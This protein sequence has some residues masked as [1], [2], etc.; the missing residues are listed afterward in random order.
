MKPTGLVALFAWLSLVHSAWAQGT[1]EVWIAQLASGPPAVR[2]QAAAALARIADPSAVPPL[3]AALR[4]PEVQVRREAAKALGAIKPA[5]AAGPLVQALRDRDANVRTHAAYALGEIKD[6]ATGDAL[7]A[8]LSDPE[9]SVRDQAAWALRQLNDPKLVPA[10]VA[11]F[12]AEHAD[13]PHIAWLLQQ[14]PGAP[15]VQPLS[16]L[17]T[18]PNPKTRL[19]VVQ[20][21]GRLED[22]AAV[23][24]LLSAL[25]DRDPTV[26]RSAVQALA[27]KKDPRAL[28]PLQKLAASEKEA[29]VREAAEA[30]LFQLSRR[31]DLVAHWSFDD[32]N[33]KTAADVT[34]RGSDGQILG[35]KPVEGK[36]GAALRFDGNGYIELGRPPAVPQAPQ[37]QTIMAWVLSETPSGVVIARGGAFSGFSLY[38]KDGLPK[39]GIH[40]VPDEPALIVA[41]PEP[42]VGSWVHLAAVMREDAIEL[43]VNGKLA[44]TTKT[45]GIPGG[46]G[47]GMEIG[48]D[49]ANSPAEI[50]DHFQG[51]IDEVK[52][53]GAA[54]ST[55]EIAQQCR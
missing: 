29:A 42:V 8:A 41:G 53:F 40:V 9:W 10:L 7:L 48:F 52:I 20:I 33:V 17:L 3:C 50:T 19:Q 34:G 51:I 55:D 49:V 4:D 54:L 25:G 45:N 1:A 5:A 13:I 30:A 35:C 21:L 32:R 12:S 15:L 37:P 36:V 38:L 39:F 23:E 26:R 31:A 2:R 27:R 46:G 47:Q 28:A 24:P 22:K 14:T 44:G 18:N 16:G 43:Y 11:A 6:P